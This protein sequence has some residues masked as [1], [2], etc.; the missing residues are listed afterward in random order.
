MDHEL[1]KRGASLMAQANGRP[2]VLLAAGGTGGHLFP[3]EA[4]S[5]ALGQRGVRVHLATDARATRYG[6]QF[7][8]EAIHLIASET[9]RGRNPIALAKTA[10]AL[11]LGLGQAYRLLGRMGPAAVVGFGGYPTI[12]PV[13]AAALRRIPTVIHDSN[14]VIGRANRLL[15]GRATAIATTF[16]GVLADTPQLAAK[17][18]HT[19]NPVRPAVIAAAATPY[20]TPAPAGP[21]RVLVFGGS[22]GAR[23]MADIVP[24]AIA[25]LAPELRQRLAVVQQ[26]RDE[27]RARVGAG[28]ERLGITAEIAPF[29]PDLPA[30]LAQAHLIVSRSGA[31]TVAELAAIGRPSILVPLPGAL[32]QDQLANANVL[33]NAGGAVV[34]TQDAFTPERLAREIDALA[35]APERLAAMAA[36]AKTAGVLDGAE[37]LAELVVTVANIPRIR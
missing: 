7:P 23:V 15:S 12:P 36:A 16:P 4:L 14:A 32:D 9:V 31:S 26:A 11:G 2:L 19:G 35:G 25:R 37:R 20:A 3:A 34:L 29:F 17:A 22:Q 27:D 24:D 8:A 13:F 6:A 5:V 10:A 18:T 21:L 28:Y 33:G 30:R 1:R